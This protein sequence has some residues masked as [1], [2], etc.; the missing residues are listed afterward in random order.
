M[1]ENLN[2]F[3]ACVNQYYSVLLLKLQ[4]AIRREVS[5]LLVSGKEF[6]DKPATL[7]NTFN[8]V[9]EALSALYS[10][11][12]ALRTANLG[13]AS[14]PEEVTDP[15]LA[16]AYFQK[17]ICIEL[18]SKDAVLDSDRLSA[19]VF[20]LT[21]ERF[22]DKMSVWDLMCLVPFFFPPEHTLLIS[23]IEGL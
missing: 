22:S 20:E 7:D 21:K 2:R 13:R 8:F 3:M 12:G 10:K 9:V 1:I 23:E 11:E 6:A 19:Q 14:I 4:P 18:R 16:M 17:A 15:G 5:K